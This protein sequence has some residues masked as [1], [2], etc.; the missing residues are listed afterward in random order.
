MGIAFPVLLL[1]FSLAFFAALDFRRQVK[2]ERL[3]AI[4]YKRDAD[5]F[6]QLCAGLYRNCDVSVTVNGSVYVFVQS[7]REIVR[8]DKVI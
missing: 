5:A 8:F 4:Q 7:S 6:S 1:A 2:S 3:A